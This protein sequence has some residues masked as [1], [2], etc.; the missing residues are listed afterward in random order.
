MHWLS[1]YSLQVLEKPNGSD[2]KTSAYFSHMVLLAVEIAGEVLV[3]VVAAVLAP[4][5]LIV[6]VLAYFHHKLE[7]HSRFRVQRVPG[8]EEEVLHDVPVGGDL[9]PHHV[10]I[11]PV[12]FPELQNYRSI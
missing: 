5:L 2:T 4:V 10:Q 1:C 9:L 7:E 12:E 11:N 8:G 3:R 6:D